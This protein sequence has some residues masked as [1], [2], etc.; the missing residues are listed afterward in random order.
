[1]KDVHDTQPAIYTISYLD[2]ERMSL[3]VIAPSAQSLLVA[4]LHFDRI[5]SEASARNQTKRSAAE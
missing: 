4:F 3:Y 1:V 2:Y 5:T